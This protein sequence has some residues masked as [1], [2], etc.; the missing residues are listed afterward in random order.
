[1]LLRRQRSGG[2]R[3]EASLGKQFVRPYLEKKL[4][5]KQGLWNGSNDRANKHDAMSS[6]PMA[7]KKKK[8]RKS[9]KP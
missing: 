9:A 2:S 3:F 1:L 8:E 5:T 4:I 7:P 6:N